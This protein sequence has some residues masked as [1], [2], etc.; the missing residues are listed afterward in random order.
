MRKLLPLDAAQI[1][2]HTAF[3]SIEVS[4]DTR[5]ATHRIAEAQRFNLGDRGTAVTQHTCTYRTGVNH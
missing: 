2:L 1:N 3:T 5:I 4:K